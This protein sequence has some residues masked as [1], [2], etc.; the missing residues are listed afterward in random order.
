MIKVLFFASLRE[1]IGQNHLSVAWQEG[2]TPERLWQKITKNSTLPDHILVACNQT[3]CDR[4]T[5]LSEG[6]EVAFFPPVTG[7]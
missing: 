6:D 3:Y 2:L 4:D 5:P 7:G 1:Q